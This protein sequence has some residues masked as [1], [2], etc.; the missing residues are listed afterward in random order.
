MDQV[1][2]M[3]ATGDSALKLDKRSADEYDD[4]MEA[5][6]E[7]ITAVGKALWAMGNA[8]EITEGKA[9]MLLAQKHVRTIIS[10]ISLDES[11]TEEQMAK[12]QSF[13]TPEVQDELEARRN[14]SR[15]EMER[16]KASRADRMAER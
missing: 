2:R 7:T 16:R 14:A 13:A 5:L 1:A 15:K 4:K 11:V 8:S 12:L 6:G 10:L 3:Q 9:K